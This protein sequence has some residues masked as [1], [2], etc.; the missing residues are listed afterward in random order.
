MDKGMTLD[1]GTGLDDLHDFF[2]DCSFDT[3]PVI[4]DLTTTK[5]SCVK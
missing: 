2:Q 1:K 4:V 5:Y 3:K